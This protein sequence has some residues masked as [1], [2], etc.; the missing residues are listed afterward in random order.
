MWRIEVGTAG[1]SAIAI[2]ASVATL[3]CA[4]AGSSGGGT[5]G[6]P[7]SEG[8]KLYRGHCGA[9]HRL[10]DPSE[11]TRAEWAAAV[12]KFGPRAHLDPRDRPAVIEYLQARAK[13]A[14]RE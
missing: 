11:R 9:C 5:A 3:A 6:A 8:E 14:A 1:R 10:R 7:A 12:E 2:A 4:T 13:D